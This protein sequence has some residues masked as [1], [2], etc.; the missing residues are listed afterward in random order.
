MAE[1]LWREMRLAIRAGGGAGLALAFFLIVVLISALGLGRDLE[2]LAAAAP[3]VLWTGALLATLLSLDRLFQADHEDGS[4][5]ALTLSPSPLG[6]V[7]LIKTLAHWLTTG[8]PLVVLSPVM[9]VMLNL[10]AAT[11]GWM[12]ASLFVGTL[13]LSSIGAIGAA[14]TLG[15]RRGGL[16]LSLLV[17]PLY[18]PTLVFGVVT[19]RNATEGLAPT[20]PFLMLLGLSLFAV[21][22]APPTAAAALRVNMS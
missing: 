19:L 1:M 3:G 4:L 15:V 6:L 7:V 2:R 12:M 22:L 14:L 11:W 20:T 5:D 21:V 18:V 10:E 16:L 17:M 8:V 13:A 9:A